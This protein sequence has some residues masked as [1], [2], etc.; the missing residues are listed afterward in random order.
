MLPKIS[1]YLFIGLLQ[2]VNLGFPLKKMLAT[3]KQTAVDVFRD[4]KQKHIAQSHD[5]QC[6]VEIYLTEANRENGPGHVSASFIKT[7]GDKPLVV[8]HTSYLP[9]IAGII[10]G[11]FL[12]F[13]PVLAK[14][15]PDIRTDD[16]EKA[17]VILRLPLSET[18]FQQGISKQQQLEIDTD[19]GLQ[20]Y[21]ITGA[22]NPVACFVVGLYSAYLGAEITTKNYREK[23]GL[24][25]TEDP[26]GIP[27]TEAEQHPDEYQHIE[28]LNCTAAVQKVLE[29]TGLS[30]EA[31]Y[32]V[33]GRLVEQL[34]K[35]PGI[36]IVE[37]SLVNPKTN[38]LD[39]DQ[40]VST[41][42]PDP[43]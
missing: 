34:E 4:K 6:C 35:L 43:D 13:I 33:P 40:E 11:V 8:T 36:Q 25:P 27:I 37:H 16:L 3:H 31:D 32:V 12:G 38:E 28:L 2:T 15:F 26:M 42:I 19:K 30:F 24:F 17:D 10:N 21:A 41:H 9:G 1:A 14:N 20:A 23:H 7:T 39:D 5:T 29:A 18:E 22:G